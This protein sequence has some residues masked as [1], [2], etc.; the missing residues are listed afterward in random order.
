[1]RHLRIALALSTALLGTGNAATFTITLSNSTTGTTTPWSTGLLTLSPLISIG[2]APQAP[3]PA[4]LTKPYATYAFANSHCNVSDS[5]CSG[6]CNDNGNATVLAQRWGLTIGT[7]AWIVPAI[8]NGTAQ[9]VTFDAPVGSRLSYIAWINNTGNFDDFVAIHPP[10]DLT[11]LSVPLF[12]ASNNPL[13]EIIYDLAGYDV[14]SVSATNGSGNTCAAECPVSTNPACYVAPGNA[15]LGTT[16]SMPPSPV[17]NV[18][19]VSGNGQNRIAWTNVSPHRG[20][21][22]ARRSR[23]SPV[24]WTPTNGTVYTLDQNLGSQTRVAY[25]DTGT[26]YVDAFNDTGLTNGTRYNYK[27]FAFSGNYIYATGNVP[28]SS[29]IFSIP[30]TKTGA[31]PLWCYSVGTP[32]VQQPVTELGAAIFTANNSGSVTA[33]RTT[34]GTAA[35]DGFERWRPVQLS[36]GVQSRFPVVPLQGK[37]GTYIVTGDQT[38]RA[39]AIN[40]QDGGVTWRANGGNPLDAGDIIQAQPG[41]QLYAFSN[42]AFTSWAQAAPPN[43]FGGA[44]DMVFVAT[45]LSSSLNRVYGLRSTDGALMWTYSPGN[46][47]MVNGGMFVDYVTNRLYVASR[48]GVAGQPTVR[49]LSTLTGQSVLTP[50]QESALALGDIDYGLNR[51]FASNQ[52]YVINNAGTAYGINMTTFAVAWTSPIG[53][54]TSYIWPLGNG[55][56]ASLNPGNSVR[57]YAMDGGTPVLL[58]QTAVTGP[59]GVTVDYGPTGSTNPALQKVYVGSSQGTVRQILLTDGGVEKTVTVSTTAVGTPTLD[60]T[61]ARLHIGTFDGRVC[62]FPAPLP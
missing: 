17:R 24:T 41:V 35:T 52:V 54:T 1:M 5:F 60:K 11:T 15:S 14:N 3:P 45:R 22:V 25:V 32:S 43:G 9:T 31:N 39:Y 20:V 42:A 61:A 36:G 19:A 27:V 6:S 23:N 59:T 21:V 12:D 7:D 49:V 46:M 57:R 44:T 18:T 47:G 48:A 55:F 10:G 2:L 26:T 53:A 16:G 30:T 8:P 51:D 29:G 58:W 50:A 37:T 34:T 28:T 38:G 56:L 4:A 62:A 33:N 13:P 40:A